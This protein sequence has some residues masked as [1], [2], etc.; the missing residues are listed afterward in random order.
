MVKNNLL[1]KTNGYDKFE[2][3][4]EKFIYNGDFNS[5]SA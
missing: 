5:L 2:D 1:E 3:N 4:V